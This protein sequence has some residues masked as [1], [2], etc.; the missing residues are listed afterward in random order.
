[1]DGMTIDD[2]K[3]YLREHWPTFGL[4][5]SREPTG[6]SRSSGSKYPSRTV[7]S[8]NSACLVSSTD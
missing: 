3:G 7:G 2:A 1:M 6:R 8:E 5:C 4:N